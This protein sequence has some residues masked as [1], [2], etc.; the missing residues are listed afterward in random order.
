MRFLPAGPDIP[1]ELV[2]SQEKGETIFICGAGVSRGAGL[3]LFRGLVEGV[4]QQLGEDWNL[5][6]L[7][8]LSHS[9]RLEDRHSELVRQYPRAF[10]RLAN[11]LIDPALFNVPGDLTAFLQDCAAADPSI[12]N[13]GAY[14]RLYGLRRQRNA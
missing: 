11:T 5:Y 8:G 7:Y 14:V 13:D 4:Y 12:V 9:L 2:S 1:P 6:E 10:V 3:P